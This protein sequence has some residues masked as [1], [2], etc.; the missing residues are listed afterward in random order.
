MYKPIT[1]YSIECDKCGRI[2][3]GN[4]NPHLVYNKIEDISLY[5]NWKVINGKHYCAKC[6][7]E[8]KNK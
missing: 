8:I 6:Y 7:E 2:F 3:G 5:S 4:V 1:V